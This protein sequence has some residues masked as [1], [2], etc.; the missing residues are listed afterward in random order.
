MVAMLILFFSCEESNDGLAPYEGTRPVSDLLI[1][2]GSFSP[3]TTW[4]GGYVSVFAVN[5]GSVAALD[6][7]LIWIISAPANGIK[8]PVQFNLVPEGATDLTSSYG[9]SKVDNLVEDKE[10]T[11]WVMKEDAWIQI[12]E[13]QGKKIFLNDDLEGSPVIISED[14]IFASPQVHTQ[15]FNPLDVYINIDNVRSVG[16]LATIYVEQ[17]LTSNNPKFSW[18][19]KQS[20]VTDSLIAA[21]GIV[22]GQSYNPNK[23]VWDVYSIDST[24]GS[25]QYGTLNLIESPL[26]SGQIIEGTFAFVAYPSDGFERDKDYYIWIANNEWDGVGRTRVADFYAY[27]TFHTW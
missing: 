3:K 2:Q 24:S 25:P 11:F 16:K 4:V 9:G 22:E 27:V 20:G 10:Y 7:S 18:E 15:I 17:P 1:E 5:E 8:Y 21:V 14:S 26:I 12:S 13:E 6:S 19:I 23:M